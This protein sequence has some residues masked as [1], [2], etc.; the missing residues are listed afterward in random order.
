VL[1]GKEQQQ[2]GEY[3]TRWL[4]M[5]PCDRLLIVPDGGPSNTS[6]LVPP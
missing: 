6:G 1:K 4:V 2:F 5:E 3:R